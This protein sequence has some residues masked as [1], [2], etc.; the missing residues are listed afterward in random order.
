MQSMVFMS[1]FMV[2]F[3][4]CFKWRK[5]KVNDVLVLSVIWS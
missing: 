3:F 2:S 4:V 5:D 1:L